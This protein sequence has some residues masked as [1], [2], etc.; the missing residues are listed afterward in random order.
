MTRG[1]IVSLVLVT[2]VALNFAVAVGFGFYAPLSLLFAVLGCVVLL[3]V[4]GGPAA[5]ASDA[6]P[7][8]RLV[9]CWLMA[10]ALGGL[11][12]RPLLFVAS[13]GLVDLVTVW[14]WVLLGAG[15]VLLVASLRSTLSGV[16]WGPVVFG[17]LTI[18]TLLRLLVPLASPERPIDVFTMREVDERGTRR[19]META[20]ELA[21]KGTAGFHLSFDMDGVDCRVAPGVGTPVMGGLTYRESHLI[22]E[23][24]ART[25]TLLVS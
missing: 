6:T 16:R 20:M 11:V 3:F 21:G 2:H 24:V 23:Q 1:R 4:A 18:A 10:L 9:A 17:V 5:D 15:A 25:G 13:G 8:G 19:V 7:S 22:C 12:S 14:N